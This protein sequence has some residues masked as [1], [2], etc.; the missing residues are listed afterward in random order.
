M[1]TD[2]NLRKVPAESPASVMQHDRKL[3]RAAAWCEILSDPKIATKLRE[4]LAKPGNQERIIEEGI[5]QNGYTELISN[6][7]GLTSIAKLLLN[8]GAYAA[9]CRTDA[10]GDFLSHLA[11]NTVAAK[12]DEARRV[13]KNLGISIR[14]SKQK[15]PEVVMP[16]S[17]LARFYIKEDV[18]R[19][20]NAR[21]AA[22]YGM[23]ELLGEGKFLEDVYKAVDMKKEYIS[24][25]IRVRESKST[26]ERRLALSFS[27]N[28][29][30]RFTK[31]FPK[32]NPM[33]I[34]LFVKE[35]EFDGAVENLFEK[36]SEPSVE[37]LQVYF[38][39][40]VT[41]GVELKDEKW[42]SGN[43]LPAIKF[44]DDEKKAFKEA[45]KAI[46]AKIL[47]D[48]GIAEETRKAF[49]N[50]FPK[51]VHEKLVRDGYSIVIFRQVLKAC[52]DLSR[53]DL[54]LLIRPNSLQTSPS[55]SNERIERLI[56]IAYGRYYTKEAD[57][58]EELIGDGASES[59]DEVGPLEER[60][61]SATWSEKGVTTEQLATYRRAVARQ[62]VDSE[63]ATQVNS[64]EE[65]LEV[66]LGDPH[67]DREKLTIATRWQGILNGEGGLNPDELGELLL[68]DTML[69][70]GLALSFSHPERIAE[71]ILAIEEL[72][73]SVSYKEV[74]KQIKL[75]KVK[76]RKG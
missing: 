43:N 58:P 50:V 12:Y 71:S 15:T 65:I 30:K 14:P 45:R 5:S 25:A 49:L 64:V 28:S 6:F 42:Q 38:E 68:V 37:E 8:N 26:G 69:D 18:D 24:K 31:A 56:K 4:M 55:F 63:D 34:L 3:I 72:S 60:M 7:V 1:Y 62:I 48:E 22:F 59:A 54:A 40:L 44:T 73:T 16:S 19:I 53:A 67:S 61:E 52:P 10:S 2:S 21:L 39:K 57:S 11:N 74:V 33:G 27:S 51:F 32:C 29:L 23:A 46:V 36:G 17:E 9:E 35:A 76:R 47:N 75:G 13:L 70:V 66:I 41:R 20:V